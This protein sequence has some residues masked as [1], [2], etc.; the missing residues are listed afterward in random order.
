LK[1]ERRRRLNV[2]HYTPGTSLVDIL[3]SGIIKLAT[4][5]ISPREIPVVWLST[6]EEWEYTVFKGV[7]SN[8]VVLH[9]HAEELEKRWGRGRILI[10]P[11]VEVC[12]WAIHRKQ[13]PPRVARG[14]ERSARQLGAKPDEWYVAYKPIERA[15]WIRAEYKDDKG[16]WKDFPLD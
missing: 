7:R 9:L 4:A 13:T 2:Y 15:N 6:N 1:L 10:S 5:E 12:P 8:S 14:L 16:R 11:E 3:E